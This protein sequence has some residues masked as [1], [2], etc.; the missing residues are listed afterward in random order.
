M[1][2]DGVMSTIE[3][4]GREQPTR[5]NLKRNDEIKSIKLSAF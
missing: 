2:F 5:S 3:L 1:C 4:Q